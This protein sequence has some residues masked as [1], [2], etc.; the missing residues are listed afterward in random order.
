MVL[1]EI[2]DHIATGVINRH[3]FNKDEFAVPYPIPSVATNH[4]S[5]N[6]KES[7]YIWRGPTWTVYN[8]FLH[9]CLIERGFRDEAKRTV[10]TLK[11]LIS[12]DGFREYYNP[13]TGEGYGAVDFTWSGL[14]V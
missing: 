1:K 11:E 12:R 4:P 3:L 6:L 14:V 8:W 2:P 7:V 10:E 13:F 9:Q 5:F